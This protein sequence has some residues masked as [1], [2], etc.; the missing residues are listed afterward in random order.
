M[1]FWSDLAQLAS[2]VLLIVGAVLPVV[3]PLGDAALFLHMTRGCDAEMR[4]DLAWRITL[5]SFV[6]LLGST[7]LGS[8]VLRLFDLSIPVVQLAG[9]AVVC[10]LGWNMLGSSDP[11]PVS[12]APPSDDAKVT[13][14]ARAFYPLTLPLTIDPGAISVAI[15]VGANHTHTVERVMV[16]IA[17]A[18]IGTAIVAAAILVTYRYAARVG[19]WI[20]HTGMMVMLRMS[21]FIVLCIGVQIGW[22]GV[23]S[24]L[25]TVRDPDL[26]DFVMRPISGRAADRYAGTRFR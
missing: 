5:Y 25:T 11:P 3:N 19:R 7:L 4:A 10:A 8:L 23:R 18:L 15:T 24:L 16:Q 2:A 20:G 21:A 1:M 14:F 9:G 13:A 17:A 22:N 6:L 12:Q 26:A